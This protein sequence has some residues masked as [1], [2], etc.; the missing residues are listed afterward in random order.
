MRSCATSLSARVCRSESWYG[1]LSI[2]PIA[3]SN[4]RG[5]TASRSASAS[6]RD[7]TQPWSGDDA[8][9]DDASSGRLFG[10]LFEVGG[11]A[12][13]RDERRLEAL[14]DRLLGDHAL[15]DVAA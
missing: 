14:L 11:L 8:R 13:G 3:R 4:G 6:G 9:G 12:A 15:G 7:R 2:R 5:S 10:E 1:A